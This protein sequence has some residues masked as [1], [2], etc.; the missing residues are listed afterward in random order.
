MGRTEH[1]AR[2][3]ERRDRRLLARAKRK[4][5][6]APAGARMAGYCVAKRAVPW[7]HVLALPGGAAYFHDHSR[8][9]VWVEDGAEP[10]ALQCTVLQSTAQVWAGADRGLTADR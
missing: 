8:A 4:V 10:P 2:K 7:R 1:L 5:P 3:A 6:P 9:T